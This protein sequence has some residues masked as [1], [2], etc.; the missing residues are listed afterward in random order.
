M[1]SKKNETKK[2]I[3]EESLKRRMKETNK[4]TNPK[5]LLFKSKDG[6]KNKSFILDQK[7]YINDKFSVNA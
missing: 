1:K 5:L 3:N 2:D 4:R 7:K 6:I